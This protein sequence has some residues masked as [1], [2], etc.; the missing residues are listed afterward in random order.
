MGKDD[1]ALEYYEESV[2][3][4]SQLHEKDAEVFFSI[5]QF[6]A[7]IISLRFFGIHISTVNCQISRHLKI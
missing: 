2:V 4:L 7:S 5:Y 1:D 6:F 3:M